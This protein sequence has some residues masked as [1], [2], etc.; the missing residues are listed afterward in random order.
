MYTGILLTGGGQGDGQQERPGS[1]GGDLHHDGGWW[2][3]GLP[4]MVPETEEGIEE[5][6]DAVSRGRGSGKKT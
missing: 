1:G 4:G 6:K 3:R 2:G 5:E